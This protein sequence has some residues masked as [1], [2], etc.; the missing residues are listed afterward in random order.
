M[1]YAVYILEL[2]N[3]RWYVGQTP[4]TRLHQ[5]VNEHKYHRG[6]KW[7]HRHGVVRVHKVIF[8]KEEV[9]RHRE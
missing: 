2:N 6:A 5:R 9:G 1:L 8:C 7:S 3:N 4:K